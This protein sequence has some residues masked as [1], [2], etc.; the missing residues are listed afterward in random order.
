M[1]R[2]SA[3]VPASQ[4]N[5]MA[6][7]LAMKEIKDDFLGLLGSFISSS[8]DLNPDMCSYLTSLEGK[9]KEG[10]PVEVYDLWVFARLLNIRIRCSMSAN[11]CH[12]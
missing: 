11:V 6:E 4:S 10:E 9:I 5:E 7:N 3:G 1:P 8:P 2:N 12:S